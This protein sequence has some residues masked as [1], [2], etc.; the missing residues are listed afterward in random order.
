MFVNIPEVIQGTLDANSISN[1]PIFVDT[2]D[3]GSGFVFNPQNPYGVKYLKREVFQIYSALLNERGNPPIIDLKETPELLDFVKHGL[4]NS[5]EG[6]QIER[7]NKP[8][9]LSVWFHIS[10]ACNL[11]CSYCYIPNLTKAVDLNSMS[12]HFM[13]SSTVEAATRSLFDFCLENKFS[14]LQIKFAGG[15]P[16]LNVERINQTCEQA[17]R[18]SEK[19]GIRV[20]FRILTNGVFV[21]ESIFATFKKYKFGVSISVDGDADRHNEIRFT[22]PRSRL[23][24][25]FGTP[26]KV[27]SWDIIN[28]NIDKLLSQGTKPYILCTVT[29]KNYRHL[30]NLVE[31]CISKKIGFRL[32]PVRDKSSH[33]KPDIEKEMLSELIKI[34]EWIGENMPCSMPIERFSRFAEWDLTVKKLSVCGTC[35]STMSIDQDGK[36]ASCQMRMDKPFG[37]IND[38]RLTLI[39]NRIKEADDNKYLAYPQT[40][41]EDCSIC[42]WKFACGGGCPEHTRMVTGTV[43]SP[44]PWCHLYQDLLPFYIRAIA[45]QIKRSI[46]CPIGS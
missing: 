45:K 43:N 11:G 24:N 23:N 38:E 35:K 1:R 17:E 19:Y 37:N 29:Q 16:T 44:S 28:L 6:Y 18:L 30:L 25:T 42:Y 12:D 32:S 46:D 9:A 2:F 20:G 40:K 8:K 39:F 15:E 3:D 33:L 21:N 27:G 13:S 26:T 31:Y 14:H 5:I 34:Y 22:V 4:A 10:N 7:K 36:V 41:S